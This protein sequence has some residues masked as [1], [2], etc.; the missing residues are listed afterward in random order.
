MLSNN[1]LKTGYSE[2]IA[3]NVTFFRHRYIP[4]KKPKT[5]DP[6]FVM[7]ARLCYIYWLQRQSCFVFNGVR[8]SYLAKVNMFLFLDITAR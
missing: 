2:L 7:S 3:V 8:N 5:R 4:K 6:N 1:C